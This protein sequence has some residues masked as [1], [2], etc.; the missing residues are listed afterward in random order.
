MNF[1]KFDILIKL[2]L[3]LIYNTISNPLLLDKV[4][5]LSYILLSSTLII[6]QWCNL[7][8]LLKTSKVTTNI[9]IDNI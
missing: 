3:V 1:K 2:H 4:I 7:I 5:V 9:A 8:K 6:P